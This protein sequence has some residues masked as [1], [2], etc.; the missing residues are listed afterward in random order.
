MIHSLQTLRRSPRRSAFTLIEL[1]VVIAIIAILAA[2]LLPALSKAKAKAQRL[3]CVSNQKQFALGFG[4]FVADHEDRYPP[5]SYSTGGYTYQLTW[6]DYLHKY[7]GGTDT[8]DDLMLGISDPTHVPGILKCPADRIDVPVGYGSFAARRS[9]AMNG[10]DMATINGTTVTLPA[11]PTHGVGV[12]INLSKDG[13][14]PADFWEPPGY[15]MPVVQDPAGTLLMVELPDTRNFA[16]NDWPSFC[17]A[18]LPGSGWTV[19]CF[20]I[21]TGSY[22]E[23]KA[24]Y[25]LHSFRF[26]YLFH[27]G[28]VSTLKY[29]DTVGSGTAILPKG[30]WTVVRGD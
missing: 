20:Q 21:G 29:T 9:Y 17:V 5:A 28:H 8:E 15:K 16:G 12:Y 30:M 7:I 13:Y 2:M 3:Q 23:G 18:P 11:N 14:K 27:D 25:G 1:L 19:D 6:D 22:A 26:N 4:M 10:A 24:S